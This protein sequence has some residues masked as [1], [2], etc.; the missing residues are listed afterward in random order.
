VK[1]QMHVVPGFY[2]SKDT[3]RNTLKSGANP[4]MAAVVKTYKELVADPLTRNPHRLS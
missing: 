3:I 4:I 1:V 2:E